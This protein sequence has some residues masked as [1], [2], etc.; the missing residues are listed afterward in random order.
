[1][2]FEIDMLEVGNAD[3]IILRYLDENKKEYIVLIDAGKTEAHGKKVVDHIKKYTDKKSV[4]LAISTHPDKDHIY[5]F[6]YV[7]EHIKID[8]FWI[9]DPQAHKIDESIITSLHRNGMHIEK[10]L[11]YV[12]ESLNFSK[13]LLTI[14][15]KMEIDREEPLEGCFH[16]EIPIRVLGPSLAY[17]KEKLHSFRDIGVLYESALEKAESQYLLEEEWKDLK[18]KFDK[19]V[20]KSNENNSS[21]IILFESDGKKVLFT[22]DA[23]P[24]AL[25]PV[26]ARYDLKDLYFL[27]VPHH[28]SENNL[29]TTIMDKLKPKIAY[30]SCGDNYPSPFIVKYLKNLKSS[31]FATKNT[32][33]IMHNVNIGP[34]SG[35]EP[36]QPL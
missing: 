27:D 26:I 14:I 19:L 23:G 6:F 3:A 35:W 5:G 15:D 1:M 24:Q 29:T 21:A 34:R 17:Y 18:I 30:I 20:D 10:G 33:G 16:P 7:I 8:K 12:V 22:S 9:H 31:V 36:I 32:K 2:P 11:K 4:D 25:D 28:G 13:N